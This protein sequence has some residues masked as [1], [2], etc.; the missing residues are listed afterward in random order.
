MLHQPPGQGEPAASQNLLYTRL[1]YLGGGAGF[2]QTKPWSLFLLGVLPPL[3]SER[4]LAI[5][6][7]HMSKASISEANFLPLGGLTI[8]FHLIKV[9]IDSPLT[10]ILCL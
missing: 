6:A 9:F 8:Q 2:L 3:G 4:A 5:N 10:G 1:V 7:H